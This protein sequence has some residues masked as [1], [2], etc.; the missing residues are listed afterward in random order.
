MEYRCIYCGELEVN[1]ISYG[2]DDINYH[3]LACGRKYNN[4]LVLKY[5][6]MS[7]WQKIAFRAKNLLK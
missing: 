1:C 4:E 2:K 7:A 3:C 5:R 6:K